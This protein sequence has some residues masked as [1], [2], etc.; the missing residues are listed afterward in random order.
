MSSMKCALSR[1]D[2]IGFGERGRLARRLRPLAEGMQKDAELTKKSVAFEFVPVGGT[3]TGATETV[4]LPI[5]TELLRLR[6]N[7]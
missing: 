5:S 1:N 7:L 2:A 4:A 3:P 6:N